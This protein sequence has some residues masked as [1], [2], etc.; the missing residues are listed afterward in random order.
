[1]KK[2]S[3]H[4]K[5]IK[6]TKDS[7]LMIWGNTP[8]VKSG[9]AEVLQKLAAHL[10]SLGVN[11]KM[12]N[13]RFDGI[14]EQNDYYKNL[15][16][17]N[18]GTWK[19]VTDDEN[20][21]LLIPEIMIENPK[22]LDFF[23]NFKHLQLII[24]W[25]SSGFD[26]NDTSVKISRRRQLLKLKSIEDRCLHLY[27][28]EMIGRD[29]LYYGITNRIKFQHGLHPSFYSKRN[30]TKEDI[31]LYNACKEVNRKY[32]EL[33]KG[34]LPNIEFV[35]L[36]PDK[37]GKYLT[38][39][40]MIALYDKAKVY[41]DFYEYEGREMCP[42]EAAIRDC[43]LLLPNEGCA[44]TFDDYPIPNSYK[45]DKYTDNGISSLCEKIQD[46]L[47]NY[48]S[49]IID[50]QLIKRKCLLEPVEWENNIYLVFGEMIPDKNK[51]VQL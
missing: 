10:K 49:K 48:D 3:V 35:G 40:E 38:K 43:L 28:N 42:R 18:Y 14:F 37:S 51:I 5:M 2:D 13:Y 23:C 31:V 44:S 9:G 12:F 41:V 24:W 21:V 15:Y 22:N 34:S 30:S 8:E 19:E 17:I 39:E 33:V 50:M 27:E 6:I 16:D 26:Y 4:T 20:T 45:F 47:K 11:A 25:L 7:K 29:L 36:G 32:I 1:M 46:C